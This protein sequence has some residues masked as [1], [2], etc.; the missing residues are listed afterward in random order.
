MTIG[1]TLKMKGQK[2]KIVYIDIYAHNLNW[3]SQMNLQ[4]IPAPKNSTHDFYFYLLPNIPFNSGGGW[5]SETYL[6]FNRN[7]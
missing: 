5:G 7:Y 3:Q 6:N 2:N 4:E 1:L